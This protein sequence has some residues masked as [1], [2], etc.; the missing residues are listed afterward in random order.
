LEVILFK[1]N[2]K[3]D[4]G[5]AVAKIRTTTGLVKEK[6]NVKE[7][8][9]QKQENKTNIKPITIRQQLTT[10]KF[11]SPLVL[12]IARTEGIPLNELEMIEGSGIDGRVTKNDLLAFIQNKKSGKL[13][14][15]VL[16]AN[17]SQ[18]T[19]VIREVSSNSGQQVEFIAMDNTRQKIMQHMILSRNTSV[20]VTA[21]MEVDMSKIHNFVEM[22]R[23]EFASQGIKLTYLPFISFAVIKALKEFPLMNSSL[24]GN[25]IHSKKFINL[26]IAV[27]VEPNGLIVPNIKNAEEKSIRGLAKAIADLG[28]RAR[29]KKL[30][31]ED[32]VNGTFSITNYGVFGSLFGTP[33]INQPEVGILG[34]GSVTKKAV[35]V[36][37]DGNDAIVIKPMMYLSLSHDHRLIDGMLGG[38]FLKSIKETLENFDTNI[39]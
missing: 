15:Q 27:A 38:K 24:E 29:T 28:T 33:I 8:Q 31:P 21:V 22:N 35:V 25:N 20:H 16:P 2:E 9:E 12:N 34:V 23:E 18:K 7:E 3:V 6:S 39:V 26:G 14:V 13:F 37:V 1:E 10:N 11:Y 32:V 30:I 17:T 36:D 19:E 4:V 5:L